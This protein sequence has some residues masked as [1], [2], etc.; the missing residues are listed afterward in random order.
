MQR[1]MQNV[2]ACSWCK[3]CRGANEN[4]KD[5]G[6]ARKVS[7]LGWGPLLPAAPVCL[8]GIENAGGL[9]GGCVG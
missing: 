2:V 5:A 8:Q 9:F 4:L 1:E 3:L 7:M 6:K